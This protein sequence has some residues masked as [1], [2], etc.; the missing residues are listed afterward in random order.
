VQDRCIVRSNHPP[1]VTQCAL[2]LAK[3]VG[4]VGIVLWKPRFFE[5]ITKGAVYR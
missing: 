5:S 1:K 2:L 4:F 3:H